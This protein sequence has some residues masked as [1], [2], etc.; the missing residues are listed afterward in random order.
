MNHGARGGPGARGEAAGGLAAGDLTGRVTGL[1]IKIHRTAGPGRLG[2]IYEDCLC[3]EM[4]L[5]GLAFQRQ[6]ELSLIYDSVRLPRAYQ[7]D[8]V[9]GE[10]VILE[11]KS[12]EYSPPFRQYVVSAPSGNTARSVIHGGRSRQG[13]SQRDWLPQTTGGTRREASAASTP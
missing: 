4:A 9:G 13:P 1:V 3:H 11:I 2:Q 12:I 10:T 5:N 8:I 6:V 7:I